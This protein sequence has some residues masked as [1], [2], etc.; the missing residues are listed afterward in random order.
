MKEISIFFTVFIT[1]DLIKRID[2][3]DDDWDESSHFQPMTMSSKW[4]RTNH[5]QL[6]NGSV[7]FNTRLSI[8]VPDR[9]YNGC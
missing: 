7:R 3:G 6:F 4:K 5:G 1:T 2:D 8:F 9:I